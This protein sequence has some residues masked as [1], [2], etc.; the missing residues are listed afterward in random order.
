M[1]YLKQNLEHNRMS[2]RIENELA[3]YKDTI[4]ELLMTQK[5]KLVADKFEVKDH[6]L[7]LF[8]ANFAQV[9]I[10]EERAHYRRKFIFNHM[11]RSLVVTA[12]FLGCGHKRAKEIHTQLLAE[13]KECENNGT[14]MEFLCTFEIKIQ[15]DIPIANGN[16]IGIEMID[17]W[18]PMLITTQV[19]D[20]SDQYGYDYSTISKFMKK[21]TGKL[22]A[23]IK[24]EGRVAYIKGNPSMSPDNICKNLNAEWSVLKPIANRVA[25][26]EFDEIEPMK[27]LT[28]QKKKVEKVTDLA[29]EGFWYSAEVIDIDE[30]IHVL[31]HNGSYRT[32]ENGAIYEEKELSNISLLNC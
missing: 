7:K 19:K 4:I 14:E 23:Q 21:H 18:A 10:N 12:K 22:P 26:G 17:V 24:F 25:R 30:E 8:V 20:V 16:Y 29:A 9:N 28:P 13:I 31:Y 5:V 15:E 3:E 1:N 6:E 11:D 2:K 27:Y 32:S